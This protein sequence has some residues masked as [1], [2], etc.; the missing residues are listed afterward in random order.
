MIMRGIQSQ[1]RDTSGL[2]PRPLQTSGRENR[3]TARVGYRGTQQLQAQLLP[4]QSPIPKDGV[5]NP[6][7]PRQARARSVAAHQ[8]QAPN[9]GESGSPSAL[10]CRRDIHRCRLGSPASRDGRPRQGLAGG[11]CFSGP[12]GTDPGPSAQGHGCNIPPRTS[13]QA[14][15]GPSRHRRI[16][17]LAA[18][19][20]A[21]AGFGA[22][23]TASVMH[24][25]CA[26]LPARSCQSRTAHRSFNGL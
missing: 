15:A 25:S 24:R 8:S 20:S 21:Q 5:G 1:A 16:R 13:G 3:H 2:L 7:T 14:V 12:R 23:S 9:I 18:S 17:R 26:S 6:S 4:R 22:R 10:T 19:V 11:A